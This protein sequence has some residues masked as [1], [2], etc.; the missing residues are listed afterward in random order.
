[1]AG[2]RGGARV[3]HAQPLLPG[4]LVGCCLDH[5]LDPRSHYANRQQLGQLRQARRLSLCP[6]HSVQ[7][8]VDPHRP[9]GALPPSG[10]LAHHRRAGHTGGY[11]CR[12]SER[13]GPAHHPGGIRRLQCRRRSLP[14]AASHTVLSLPGRRGHLHRHHLCATDGP[15]CPGDPPGAAH[16]RASL[17]R[18]AG[19]VAPGDPPA[20]Q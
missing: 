13:P 7:R 18:P 19:P 5:L 4:P 3:Y 10:E 11:H 9:D 17:P 14:V 8:P 6:G 2:R 20:G 15:Q 16:P 1:M 12:R